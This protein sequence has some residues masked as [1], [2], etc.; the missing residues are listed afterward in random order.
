MLEAHRTQRADLRCLRKQIPGTHHTSK[1]LFVEHV[2]LE[3]YLVVPNAS[4][5]E[6][7]A[8]A[9]PVRHKA[10]LFFN[11]FI[12][13]GGAF[14]ENLFFFFVRADDEGNDLSFFII[15]F[16]KTFRFSET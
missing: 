8:V 10:I 13:S 5:A 2:V 1:T 9:R 11:Y 12:F 4:Q 14:F 15:F 3:K 7:T 6:R 16:L